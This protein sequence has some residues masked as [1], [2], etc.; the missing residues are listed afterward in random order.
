M[1]LVFSIF[2]ILPFVACVNEPPQAKIKY[3]DTEYQKLNIYADT[4]VYDVL[5][6][7]DPE[8]IHSKNNLKGLLYKNLVDSIFS[9]AYKGDAELLDYFT[10]KFIT[11][12]DLKKMEKREDF[13]RTEIGKIQ[14]HEKWYLDTQTRQFKK[15]VVSLVLGVELYD[16]EGTV[17]AYKPIFKM[18]L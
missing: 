6:K 5:I 11:A 8:N 12:E 7:P 18:N 1:R 3:I 4:I 2:L 13:L 10:N 9:M 16:A 15:E 17:R 14:F